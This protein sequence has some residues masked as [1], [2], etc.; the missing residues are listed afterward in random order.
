MAHHV[1]RFP[2]RRTSKT[3]TCLQEFALKSTHRVRA[4][5]HPYSFTYII[6]FT[7][8]FCPLGN[9]P[10]PGKF[11]TLSWHRL[12]YLHTHTHAHTHSDTSDPTAYHK[13]HSYVKARPRYRQM[14][15]KSIST[16]ITVLKSVLWEA[17]SSV[18]KGRSTDQPGRHP[19]GIH[20][21]R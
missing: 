5:I 12:S 14:R 20:M 19:K 3:T 2:Y 7:V 10:S 8:L 15:V 4:Y 18:I 17:K 16:K 6:S 13:L 9:A 21:N 11:G 1:A